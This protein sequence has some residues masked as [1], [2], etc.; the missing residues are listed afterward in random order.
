[1]LA[2]QACDPDIPE[3]KPRSRLVGALA[4]EDMD[5]AAALCLLRAG[6]GLSS[7]GRDGDA[8]MQV[9]SVNT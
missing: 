7:S 6:L 4:A 9:L 5:V 3:H 1:M 2:H 8:H